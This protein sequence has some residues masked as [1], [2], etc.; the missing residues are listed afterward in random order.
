MNKSDYRKKRTNL[1]SLLPDI[2]KTSISTVL[3]ENTVNRFFSAPEFDYVSGVVGE[4]ATGTKNIPEMRSDYNSVHNQLQPVPRVNIGTASD[5][6]SFQNMMERL[7]LMGVDVDNFDDWGKS[8]QF[9]WMP[10]VN[11]DKLVNYREYFW[12]VTQSEK[13]P[14]YI[15]IKNQ[16]V[17]VDARIQ[18]ANRSL[19]D[20]MVNRKIAVTAGNTSS[21]AGNLTSI[22]KAN[23]FVILSVDNAFI[24]TKI[25]SSVFNPQTLKTDI[26]TEEVLDSQEYIAPTVL[27]ITLTNITDNTVNVTGDLS[28]LLTTGF[29]LRLSGNLET[30]KYFSVDSSSYDTQ[31]KSTVV[32]LLEPIGSVNFKKMDFTPILSM[33]YA[34]K[35]AL[36]TGTEYRASIVTEVD[37]F[38]AGELAWVRE[39][40]IIA[41]HEGGFTTN[42]SQVI[43]DTSVNFVH[44]EVAAGD[45]LRILDGANVG[46]YPII[47]VSP[48]QLNAVTPYGTFFEDEYF[49]YEVYRRRRFVDTT[50]SPEKEGAVRYNLTDDTIERYENYVWVVKERNISL[51]YKTTHSRHV[52]SRKQKD[53]WSKANHW[54]HKSQIQNYQYM[55]RAKLPIIEFDP[56]IE[57]A[58]YSFTTHEWSYKK[59]TTSNYINSTVEPTL[60]ELH[61]IRLIDGDEIQFQNERTI[62]LHHKFGYL[63]DSIKAGDSIK[64][65]DFGIN[66]GFYKVKSVDFASAF[67]NSHS[68]TIINLEDR[69][70]NI[71]V[72]PLEGYIGP[73]LTSHGD[74]WL[75][76]DAAQWKYE[77][78]KNTFACGLGREVNTNYPKIHS[79][80]FNEDAQFDTVTG[81][82]WQAFRLRSGQVAGAQLTFNPILQG[83][84]LRED[85]QE[86]DIRLYVNGERVFA[87]FFDTASNINSGFVGGIRFTNDFTITESDL[88][89]VEVGAH[90]INDMGKDAVPV[91]VAAGNSVRIELVNL[92]DIRK[93][94]QVKDETNQ[95]PLFT[96]Y[97]INGKHTNSAS[98]IFKFAE[99]EAFTVDPTT[100]RRIMGAGNEVSFEQKLLGEDDTLLCYKDISTR[101]PKI[102]SIWRRGLN[103]ETYQP[104]Q[105]DGDWVLPNQL[106]YNV[107][108]ENRAVVKYSEVYRHFKTIIDAQDTAGLFTKDKQYYHLD[109]NVNYGIG[110]TI[111]EH[112]GG[113][114]QLISATFLNHVSPVDVLTFAQEQYNVQVDWFRTYL[115]NHFSTLIVNKVDVDVNSAVVASLLSGFE[116]DKRMDE[117][118]GDTTSGVANWIAS[119]CY[120]GLKTPVAPYY[121]EDSERGIF[122]VVH[123]TGHRST[124]GF[125][126]SERELLIQSLIDNGLATKQKVA[127]H[128]VAITVADPK[129]GDLLVRRN[130]KV[131]K[132]FRFTTEWTELNLNRIIVDVILNIENKLY[133]AAPK[134]AREKLPAKKDVGFYSAAMRN[135]FEQYIINNNV[136]Y[137]YNNKDGY[138]TAD[139]FTWNYSYSSL[140]S[141]PRIDNKSFGLLNGSWAALYEQVYGTPYPHLEPWVLQGYVTKPA[142][143]DQM[144][145]NLT[146][147]NPRRWNSVMWFNILNGIVPVGA[148]TPSGTNGSGFAG[149]I[150]L[151]FDSVPVN[152]GDTV[153]L[154]GIRPDSLIPPYWN[155]KNTT[156][157]QIKPLFDAKVNHDVVT[158]HL[159][160][161]Y[162]V[163]GSWEW[164]WKQSLQFIHDD[165]IAIFQTNPMNFI[166]LTF[167]EPL[168]S[169]DCLEIDGSKN[170]VRSHKDIKFHGDFV[171][172]NT[173][174]KS[175]GINQWYVNFMRYAA[176]D[177]ESSELRAKWVK[178]DSPLTY[179]TGTFFD[180]R[181]LRI[182]H[183]SFDVTNK[184]YNV[185]TKKT[186]NVD[187]KR[188]SALT[189]KMMNIPSKYISNRDIG[190]GWVAEF[191]PTHN[192]DSLYYYP[193]E[194]FN[195]AYDAATGLYRLN[196]Y[197]VN[198]Y[199]LVQPA[200]YRVINYNQSLSSFDQVFFSGSSSV[201]YTAVVNIDQEHSFT[202]T[203][204]GG[205]STVKDA[206]AKLNDQMEGYATAELKLGNIIIRSNN[207][208]PASDI[209]VHDVNLFKNIKPILFNGIGS[210][211]F[212]AFEF[213]RSLSVVGNH[214]EDFKAGTSIT[215]SDAGDLTG[216][217]TVLKSVYDQSNSTTKIVVAESP[218]VDS[219]PPIGTVSVVN[220]TTL[221]DTWVTGKNV[222]ISSLASLPYPLDE[223]R[224]YYIVRNDASSFYLSDNK[225]SALAGKKLALVTG[226][227]NLLYVGSLDRTFKAMSGKTSKTSWKKHTIDKRYKI[228][229]SDVVSIAG[230]QNMVDFVFGY[231]AALESEGFV[232]INPDG[233]NRDIETRMVNSWQTETE[234]LINW[235]FTIKSIRSAEDLKYAITFNATSDSIT[236]DSGNVFDN[237]D[238]V[239]F[240][241]EDGATLPERFNSILLANTP[242][243]VLN[244]STPDVIRLAANPL[245]VKKNAYITF[246]GNGSGELYIRK[247]K[248]IDNYPKLELNPFRTNLWVKNDIGVL[249]NVLNVNMARY[250]SRQVIF[251]NKK[252]AMTV[253]DVHVLR[254]D[255]LS[256]VAMVGTIESGLNSK[257]S[258]SSVNDSNTKPTGLTK[259][260]AAADLRYDGYEHTI[261][262][263]DRGVDGTL[264]YDNFLG[265]KTP[266]FNIAF[267][268]QTELTLRPNMGGFI[269]QDGQ[270]V[271]NFEN[272]VNDMRYYYDVHKA[273]EYKTTT[274][275]VRNMLGYD[276]EI[277]YM[278]SIGINPK[279]QF[280]FWRGMIQNKGTNLAMEA[281]ANQELY[282]KALVDE[283]WAYKL[284]D[285][286][287][288]KQ[289]L[290]PELKLFVSDVSK[291]EIRLEFTGPEGGV[292]D[293][294]FAEIKLTDLNR[295]WEQ[296][297]VLQEMRPYNSFF[298][299]AKVTK[300]I[301]NI[302]SKLI[303]KGQS[304]YLLLE[305]VTDGAVIF[306][307]NS[308][309]ETVSLVAGVDFEFLNATVIKFKTDISNLHNVT[310]STFGYDESSNSPAFVVD[311]KSGAIVADVPI[312]HPAAGFHY[313]VGYFPVTVKTDADP[314]IYTNVPGR[315]DLDT[316]VWKGLNVGNV[317]FDDSLADYLP[318]YDKAIY[319]RTD[320]RMFEWG[321][322]ADYGQLKL[323]E[324]TESDVHPDEWDAAVKTEKVAA[325]FSNKTGKTGT[326]YKRLYK[327]VETDTFLP[328]VWEEQIDTH[329][330]FLALMVD[331]ATS[332]ALEGDHEV[333]LNGKFAQVVN[334]N[335]YSL[336]DFVNGTVPTQ[337]TVV[338]PKDYI[339][340]IK[341]VTKP[342]QEELDSGV[343]KYMTPFTLTEKYDKTRGAAYPVYY[344]WVTNKE[345][346]ITINGNKYTT[347]I[348]AE[349]QLIHN[350]NPYMILSGLRPGDAGYGVVYGNVFDENDDKLPFRY[351]QLTIKG[352]NGKV[353]DEDRYALRLVRDLTLRD[354]LP[355]G[356]GLEDFISKNNKHVEWK[357]VRESQISKIDR[358]LWDRLIESAIGHKVTKGIADYSVNLPSLNRV[359]FDKLKDSDTR[360]GLGVEQVLCDVDNTLETVVGV[361]SDPTKEY[362]RVNIAEFLNSYDFGYKSDVVAALNEI[363][364]A[365]TIDEIN[366]IF[367]AV[368][369]VAMTLK[370][371]SMD[372]FKTSWVALQISQKLGTDSVPEPL[373]MEFVDGEVCEIVEEINDIL[374][375]TPLPTPTP[376][377]SVTPTMT[378]TPSVSSSIP[379]TPTPTP[380]VTPTITVSVTVTPTP[381]VTKSPT[382][383]P[384]VTR[385]V[386]PTPT[387][388]SGLPPTVTPTPTPTISLSPEVSATPTPTVTQS[389]S[390]S[391]GF[392]YWR[393]YITANNGDAYLSIAEVEYR[394]SSGG[395]NIATDPL[396]I[397]ASESYGPN[398]PHRLIDGIFMSVWY[399]NGSPMPHWFTYDFT[400]PVSLFEISMSIHEPDRA[401]KDFVIQGSNDNA[402]WTDIAFHT[403]NT[404]WV[405]G[406]VRVF[407]AI[408]V[409]P[410][411]TPTPTVTPTVTPTPSVAGDPYWANVVA[412]LS[413]IGADGSND[414]LDDTGRVWH[415][416]GNAQIDNSLG[417]NTILL[418][419][420]GDYVY[421][422]PDPSSAFGTGDLTVEAWLYLTAYPTGAGH[423]I[424]ETL[425]LLGDGSRPSSHVFYID[426]AGRLRLYTGGANR[427]SSTSI[428]PLNTLIHVMWSREA[429]TNRFAIDGVID[430]TIGYL[431]DDTLGGFAC[432]ALG[433]IPGSAG[434]TVTGHIRAL[435][436]TRG[437]ARYTAAFTPPALPYYAPIPTPTPTI[438]VTPTL[439]PTPTPT[440]TPSTSFSVGGDGI[441]FGNVALQMHFDGANGSTTFT[442]SSS[443]NRTMIP[444][445][446][447]TIST[448]ES[449]FGGA[450]GAFSTDTG[451]SHLITDTSLDMRDGAFQFDWR[452][453]LTSNL[454]PSSLDVVITTVDG[455][456]YWA[457]EWAVFVAPT[458]LRFYYGTRGVNNKSIRF[459]LPPGYDFGALGGT[460]VAC[461]IARDATG[462]W[463]A[464]VDGIACTSFQEGVLTTA[465]AYNPVTSTPI[466]DTRDLGT[467]NGHT[468]WIGKY[469]IYTGYDLSQPKH[470]DELR[471]TVGVSRP[472]GVDYTP[473][474]IAF[475]P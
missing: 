241:V 193:V 81:L 30:A 7:E 460:Q 320:E 206:I 77:G 324:W 398:T 451:I 383:T 15:T 114:D 108:H 395:A 64:L 307:K 329:Y 413:A 29:V 147:S 5:Q 285:F 104:T 228:Q 440:I 245:D 37:S 102:K 301:E 140:G 115:F 390:G 254:E 139:P 322:L 237:G 222:Y 111:K 109:D 158:P 205:S 157:P 9:N 446:G 82:N 353:L 105:V 394:D 365:F 39:Y 40:G 60:F 416:A 270:L 381:T 169:L 36:S 249:S 267:S 369:H 466:V 251:D 16:T 210:V 163:N 449:V 183:D 58:D 272:A 310:V 152:I 309:D 358:F 23:D 284:S 304:K 318:Y 333:Y 380:T 48:T 122:E 200:A 176:F 276:G 275:M 286:G 71:N 386:T 203:L 421:A 74:L 69:L 360:F 436:V 461:S 437:I 11:I 85:Y 70:K 316:G 474:A 274:S 112:N 55:V 465:E 180:T 278:S 350:S 264:V 226:D 450:S 198:D 247:Y 456:Y 321:R 41:P 361:L 393:T 455:V 418:D 172:G 280:I 143:W 294:S 35:K 423:G 92:C 404:G 32:K 127:N 412:Q 80:S 288:V 207:T 339:H 87:V 204:F 409:P 427:L 296:P 130:A 357:L 289:K 453:R 439:T 433:D 31:A 419:G 174:Y 443:H 306:G 459:F 468:L 99:D 262:F 299:D 190:L 53:S 431:T 8:L 149:Q 216:T 260:M 34:E 145:L 311:K 326:P 227:M 269:L 220:G 303:T 292:L 384:T 277:E 10:P 355:Y 371:N 138:T 336:L 167:D 302:E 434:T 86:G 199:T 325:G 160:F 378:P 238:M 424:F 445:A 194:N 151:I 44:S 250:P 259:F 236:V 293:T 43:G 75:G 372:I 13:T 315:A 90:A 331:A 408:A 224:P 142:T 242:Y 473:E 153:T 281:F 417:Y 402:T 38:T 84:V 414:I 351:T 95:Y 128:T 218:S 54:L 89:R 435:R 56:Y 319:R 425:P 196:T 243:Y 444:D 165:L 61:N 103:N 197:L 385:T 4:I 364:N 344:F 366:R 442:D 88:I 68:R 405:D 24:A 312:W 397:S 368:L 258:Y 179:V 256:R 464:W 392:R 382:P 79:T 298:F 201:P 253:A 137:P 470:I 76:Y 133:D 178:W 33:M 182:S 83:I 156:N 166:N 117:F 65:G 98:E 188:V 63:L 252:N 215:L 389:S 430:G 3:N 233:D 438:S 356:D 221:P 367:F 377:P 230:V 314:A 239:V 164:K 231:E 17:W 12:D 119:V 463:G 379:A 26:T 313:Q 338:T 96:T 202:L 155:T 458:Y 407:S 136:K 110:G 212:S 18:Q 186:E 141:N 396:A 2:L 426:P 107:H 273:L 59:N 268:R 297:H 469:G 448:A 91:H 191:S 21:V 234:K 52:S 399:T 66:N 447:V 342:T 126:T 337:T 144:Y 283:F 192:F 93:I 150:E 335:V 129:F 343:Y 62:V 47:A 173:Y 263:N 454:G 403:G 308:S 187:V 177:G 373:P 432:G 244:T 261:V 181:S 28:L 146:P 121:I 97:D 148:K 323:Y 131:S 189:T 209:S 340:V 388:T 248:K 370:K 362:S 391:A 266:R 229:M 101:T 467:A 208:T 348:D 359:V 255:R 171:E 168:V 232:N 374:D 184:D 185:V 328:A 235:M 6:M 406:E 282:D 42:H 305:A 300:I 240:V 354:D 346:Q 49:A 217:Y 330:D 120:L 327:N 14:Q 175:S 428:L 472:V 214:T 422:D 271:D 25:V 67:N 159:D 113:F 345:N 287:D 100:L 124:V 441:P 57:M 257:F 116:N 1:N 219:A 462:T 376:S 457:Y 225:E 290:Y 415:P 352:L 162:G 72:L 387:G 195:V 45:V 341:R 452:H 279:T 132:L 211:Q 334:M 410:S 51:L 22:F 46:E 134:V 265:I 420:V 401:P 50:L 170:K 154:D 106:A 73:K 20:S 471:Y 246:T 161:E 429:S 332:D 135:G 94:E 347:L 291:K 118:F 223:E 349:K 213:G 78:I 123:H 19:F 411:P 295:W 375:A 317:W 125:N 27:E 475:T 363:Y 400:S